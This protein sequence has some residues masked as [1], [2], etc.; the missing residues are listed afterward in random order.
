MV[1][2]RPGPS[3]GDSALGRVAGTIARVRVVEGLIAPWRGLGWIA[4]TPSVWG[5]AIVPALVLLVVSG[6]AASLGVWGVEA[7]AVPHLLK[8]VSWVWVAWLLRVVLWLVAV[9]VGLF[10]GLALAQ[11]LSGP[12]LEAL[13]RKQ[14]LALGAAP[15]PEGPFFPSMLRS[16]RVTLFGLAVTLPLIALLTVIGV[17]FPVATI[18]T[19]PLKLLVS[20]CMLAWD[21]F[22]YP[23][24]VRAAG[25][26][27]RLAWFSANFGAALGFGASLAIIGLIPLAG[28]LFLPAGVAG[29]TRVVVESERGR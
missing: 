29:A 7:L 17:I 8:A 28:L 22:D 3:P 24:S 10:V 11:P 20:A 4:S 23:L 9:V 14:G 16:L 19:V 15:M 6:V 5:L 13:A 27:A 18:V 25:V 2:V 1:P 12:A 21:V 26:R